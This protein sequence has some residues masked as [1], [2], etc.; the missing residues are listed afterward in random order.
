M[1]LGVDAALKD[2]GYAVDLM[3]LDEA[4]CEI[5]AWLAYDHDLRFGLPSARLNEAPLYA[6][7]EKLLKEAKVDG[8]KRVKDCWGRSRAPYRPL[9]DLRPRF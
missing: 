9:I 1:E 4:R 6:A 8:P 2:F 7:N 3:F 5:A